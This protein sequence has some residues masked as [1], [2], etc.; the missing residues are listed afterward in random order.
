MKVLRR[1]LLGGLLSSA[2]IPAIAAADHVA[3][4]VV[5]EDSPVASI[6]PLDI[7]KLY[8]GFSVRTVGSVPLRAATNRSG[9]ALFDIFLQD[10]MAMSEKS[11]DRRLLTLTLQSGRRRPDV[12]TNID[13]LVGALQN[14]PNLVTFMWLEDFE[15]VRSLKV[16]RVIWKH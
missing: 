12:F 6:D 15:K 3:V 13:E 2:L 7:R 14:D 9:K 16:L 5:R 4:L 8:L 10:V 1:I 11:Y